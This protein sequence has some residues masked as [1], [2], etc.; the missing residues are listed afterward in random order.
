M[1]RLIKFWCR[2]GLEALCMC[3]VPVRIRKNVPRVERLTMS[4]NLLTHY[5]SCS[6]SEGLYFVRFS[7]DRNRREL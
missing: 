6:I 5:T 1:S 3:Y 2:S 7:V 4:Y